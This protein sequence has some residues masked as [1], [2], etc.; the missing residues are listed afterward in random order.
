MTPGQP[1]DAVNYLHGESQSGEAQRSDKRGRPES[2]SK[3]VSSTGVPEASGKTGRRNAAAEPLCKLT[4]QQAADACQA[5][6]VTTGAGPE[7]LNTALVAEF[8]SGPEERE[9]G[10][11]TAGKEGSSAAAGVSRGSRAAPPRG[12]TVK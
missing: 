7:G 2:R 11:L 3:F 8:S 12:V 10:S 6:A 5:S 9:P 1:V 4:L